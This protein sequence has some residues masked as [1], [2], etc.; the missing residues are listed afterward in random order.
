M[1]KGYVAS[2]IKV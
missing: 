1:I 2:H